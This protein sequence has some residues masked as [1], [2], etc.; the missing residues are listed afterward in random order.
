[1][2]K[3]KVTYLMRLKIVMN[4]ILFG[5]LWGCTSHPILPQTHYSTLY[6]T[7]SFDAE[8]LNKTEKSELYSHLKAAD[9]AAYNGNHILA[10][11]HYLASARLSKSINLIKK[12]IQSA[13]LSSDPLGLFQAS[14]LWLSLVPYDIE[15]TALKIRSLLLHQELYDALDSS[16]NFFIANKDENQRYDIIDKVIRL[17]PNAMI[18]GHWL[19]KIHEKHPESIGI[20]TNWGNYMLSLAHYSKQKKEKEK[21][22]TK[23]LSWAKKALIIQSDFL[24]AI[25][26]TARYYYLTQQTEQGEAFLRSY[27]FKKNSKSVGFLL[28]EWLYDL[29]KYTLAQLQYQILL[30]RFPNDRKIQFYLAAIHYDQ[31]KYNKSLDYYKSLLNS[32]YKPN[33]TAFL[34]GN[35]SV[36]IKDFQQAMICYKRIK[37][38][39]YYP[40]SRIKIARYYT[41]KTEFNQALK[42]IRQLPVQLNKKIIIQRF[43]LEIELL[44]KLKKEKEAQALLNTSLQRYPSNFPLMLKK[45]QF[46][47]MN[48]H[49]KALFLF[50]QQQQKQIKANVLN[51]DLKNKKRE[52]TLETFHLMVANFFQYH[53][54]YQE[55]VD[56]LTLAL[57][58]NPKHIEYLYIRSL[59]KEPLGKRA[60]MI[61]DLKKLLKLRPKNNDFKNALGYSLIDANKELNYAASLVESAF[62]EKPNNPAIIDSKGWLAYRQGHFDLAIQYLSLS[63]RL[64]PT[65]EVATH[66]AEV[67]WMNKERKK[68][69]IYFK[70]AKK[71]Q[72]NNRLLK[73]TKKRLG[74]SSL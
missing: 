2:T 8:H 68:A 45:I 20:M 31:K 38:G 22:Y 51:H 71:I 59:Y 37:N 33:E 70:I 49:P 44:N 57:K 43:N 26:L 55:S 32:G 14:E 9:K 30:K 39:V 63:L 17:D 35:A 23:A 24:P 54:F 3:N 1:M 29:K 58:E 27:W 19:K 5:F 46:K 25:Q 73:R 50:F 7:H 66:L 13:Q 28:G 61:R 74:V 41:Q 65:A 53:H 16:E 67:F 72:P 36:K 15:A 40:L 11:N 12:S 52:K 34:C 4:A 10:T 48:Q 69:L 60:E 21:I 42:F 56:W 18:N 62:F 6:Q 64:S 47:K